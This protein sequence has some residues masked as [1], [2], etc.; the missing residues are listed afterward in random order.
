MIVVRFLI[1]V[2]II[3]GGVFALAGALGVLKM[4]DTLCRMQAST[5]IPTLGTICV[6]LGAILYAAFFKH[7]AADAVK[8]AVIALMIIVTNPIGSHVLARGAYTSAKREG[9]EMLLNVDDY[10]RDFHE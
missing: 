8:I 7:S 6:A 2:L 10:G 4:P 1:D 3:A 9:T 5:C